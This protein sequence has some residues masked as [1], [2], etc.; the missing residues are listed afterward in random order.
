MALWSWLDIPIAVLVLASAR[1]VPLWLD[2]KNALAASSLAVT[3]VPEAC[4]IGL[5]SAGLAES[6]ER[7]AEPGCLASALDPQDLVMPQ[8]TPCPQCGLP[9]EIRE[10]FYLNST[11]GPVE[12]VALSC[13]DDHHFRMATDRLPAAKVGRSREFDPVGPVGTSA[14]PT[15]W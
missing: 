4:P 7:L 9:A 3:A 5:E 11:D 12:H 1:G 14:R 15:T 13:I 6:D 2:R 8:L 10:N